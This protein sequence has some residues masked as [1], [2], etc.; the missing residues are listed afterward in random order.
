MKKKFRTE[1]D[2]LGNIKVDNSRFWGAQ[3]QRSIQNFQIGNDKMPNEVIVAFGL[4][5]KAAALAN[6]ELL[7]MNKK[8]DILID[9]LKKKM[10]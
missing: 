1:S 10:F 2:S 3:T 6:M 9:L 4:Q 8:I 5:K 7:K